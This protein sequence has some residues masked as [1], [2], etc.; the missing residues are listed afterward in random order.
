M[1]QRDGFWIGD[2]KAGTSDLALN[3]GGEEFEGEDG[4]FDFSDISTNV[5]YAEFQS[6]IENA[7][8]A[9]KTATTHRTLCAN[10][11]NAS[12]HRQRPSKRYPSLLSRSSWPK[13][14]A[15]PSSCGGRVVGGGMDTPDN[16]GL[17]YRIAG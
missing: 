9:L 10:D 15:A 17:S 3:E 11:A 2:V 5:A 14:L 7:I 4:R 8:I 16:E 12:K 13:T 6:I 1:V